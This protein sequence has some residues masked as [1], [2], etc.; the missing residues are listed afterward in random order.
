[1]PQGEILRS[2]GKLIFGWCDVTCTL[3]SPKRTCRF[4]FGKAPQKKKKK[5][6]MTCGDETRGGDHCRDAHGRGRV[7][8]SEFAMTD[9]ADA[10]A[11]VL[12]LS[13]P[14]EGAVEDLPAGPALLGRVL[15][16]NVTFAEDIPNYRASCKDGYAV[17]PAA[18]ADTA[19][20]SWKI[21]GEGNDAGAEGGVRRRIEPGEAVYVVVFYFRF[22]RFFF[23]F[24]FFFWTPNT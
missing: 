1:V 22:F 9:L 19:G 18:A 13:Q 20:R 7:E 12:D 15:R 21:I 23:F 11:T 24:F 6:K 5:K 2:I 16:R 3:A 17:A 8:E 10:V 4:F 14:H